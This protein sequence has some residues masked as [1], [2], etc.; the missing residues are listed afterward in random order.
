MCFPYDSPPTAAHTEI[1]TKLIREV[2]SKVRSSG[3]QLGVRC[4]PTE[5]MNTRMGLD[6][7]DWL[8]EGLIDFCVPMLYIYFVLDAN[9]PIEWLVNA[10]HDADTSVYPV[11]QPYY[12][13]DS[14]SHP[15]LPVNHH[16]T[17][18]QVRMFRPQ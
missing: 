2:S 1:M 6:I 11:L 3:G 17:I 4:Y 7:K 8:A 9:M 10:A 15:L 5:A 16:A 13:S 18:P 14:V 12:V